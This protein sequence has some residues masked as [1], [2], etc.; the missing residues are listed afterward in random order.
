MPP[1]T[2]TGL[3]FDETRHT[4]TLDGRRVPGVTSIIGVLDKSGPLTRWAARTVAEYVWDNPDETRLLRAGSREECVRSLIAVPNAV[5][6][7]AAGRGSTIHAHAE[8]ILRGHAA[9]V[10]DVLVPV[11]QGIV[12]FL[13][14]WEIDP[15]LTEYACASREHRW[16][17]TGD[18]I[19]HY[20]NPNT[21]R[22]GVLYA[23]WKSGKNTYGES[24]LQFSA[25]TEGAEFTGLDGQE[26]PVPEVDAVY[27]VHTLPGEAIVYPYEHGPA[28]YADFLTCRAAYEIKLKANRKPGPSAYKRPPVTTEKE[29]QHV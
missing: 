11:V 24:G 15:I 2:P 5:R 17:G 6:D 18:T 13:E 22:R 29:N 1:T 8:A 28:V 12:R 19:A 4:Y 20:R 3:T 9:D 10:A 27:G 23:D 14:E 25:Y 16:A 7:G 21:G 26:R